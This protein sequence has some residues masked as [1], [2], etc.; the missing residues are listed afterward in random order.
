MTA[1]CE[2]VG[3]DGNNRPL[4]RIARHLLLIT[5]HTERTSEPVWGPH[6]ADV[7]CD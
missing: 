2:T 7:M 6:C 3:R 1:V 5:A 4:S